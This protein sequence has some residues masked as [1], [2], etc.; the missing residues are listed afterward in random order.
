[1]WAFLSARLRMWLIL[2]VGA[3]LLGW[4]LGKV[5]DVIEKRRGPSALTK[6]LQKGR[7]WLAKRSRGPLAA[8]R[9]A[10]AAGPGDPGV[11]A[12]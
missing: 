11:P 12:R 7:D 10:E 1:M 8:R 9:R 3:P 4:L 6:V 2:A 5:G